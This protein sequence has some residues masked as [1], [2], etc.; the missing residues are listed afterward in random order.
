MT[1]GQKIKEHRINLGET[2]AE[3]GQRFNASKGNVST[4]EKDISKPNIKRL[5]TLGDEMGMTVSELL[6]SD[7]DD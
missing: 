6:G 2:M 3:F 5:K 1:L 7:K 4:W